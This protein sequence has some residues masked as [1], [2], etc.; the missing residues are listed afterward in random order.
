[1]ARVQ[2]VLSCLRVNHECH[3]TNQSTREN[4]DL[5]YAQAR[6]YDKVK[7]NRLN[8]SSSSYRSCS[9]VKPGGPNLSIQAV[10]FAVEGYGLTVLTLL[11]SVDTSALRRKAASIGNVR[12]RC[13][14]SGVID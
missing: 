7:L 14:A 12:R 5:L 3:C 11:L 8:F 10:V 2:A 4:T 9:F 13:P 6:V 1:M